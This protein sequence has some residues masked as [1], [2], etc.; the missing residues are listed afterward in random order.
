MRAAAVTLS[1]PAL[2][3]LAACG[4]RDGISAVR[5]LACS[6]TPISSLA[7]GEVLEIFPERTLGAACHAVRQPGAR[8]ALAWYDTRAHRTSGLFEGF[9]PDTLPSWLL[10]ISSDAPR[11]PGLLPSIVSAPSLLADFGTVAP[12]GASAASSAPW[13]RQSPW[14]LGEFF[15]VLDFSPRSVG[16]LEG[17]P[18]RQA[19]VLRIYDDYLVVARFTNESA[20]L[21]SAYLAALDS[22][23]PLVRAH[24]PELLAAPFSSERPVTSSGSGQLLVILQRVLPGSSG[25]AWGVIDGDAAYGWFA[26]LLHNNFTDPARLGSLFVHELAHLYQHRYFYE[27]RPAGSAPI[28]LGNSRWG[29]EGGANLVSMEFLGRA[30]AIDVLA[31]YDWRNPPAG[32]GWAQVYSARAQPA[33]GSIPLGYDHAMGFLRDLMV[34]RMLAGDVYT[35]ALREVS[36]GAVEG[37]YGADRDGT[38]RPGLVARMRERHGA[39]WN[40]ATAVLEWTLSHAGDDLTA[41]PRYQNRSFLDERPPARF[42]RLAP[43]RPVRGERAIKPLVEP[44][45][46][47]HRIRLPE[48]H[49]RR[50]RVQSCG[51]DKGGPLDD[52]AGGV[53]PAPSEPSGGMMRAWVIL[54]IIATSLAG[55]SRSATGPAA[56]AAPA[57][58]APARRPPTAAEATAATRRIYDAGIA[59]VMAA[60]PSGAESQARRTGPSGR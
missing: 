36:R 33:G 11:R 7:V 42:R 19:Q 4:E 30:A 15:E 60:I 49:R 58:P 5:D 34:R 26:L 51:F 43:G 40:P 47:E 32:D 23:W 18:T 44:A 39:G 20:V 2:A 10:E 8:F 22:I 37:W 16:N 38:G 17:F 48:R 41:N 13:T 54:P 52:P 55:C 25:Y 56:P 24:A 35:T 14:S 27:S 57:A 1:I 21:T 6:L 46:G 31:N 50:S 59:R 53:T 28:D 9:R 12:P 29:V 3:L 45:V